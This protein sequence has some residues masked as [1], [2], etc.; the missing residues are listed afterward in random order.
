MIPFRKRWVLLFSIPIYLLCIHKL[1]AT[2]PKKPLAV[3]IIDVRVV[4]EPLTGNFVTLEVDYKV[5]TDGEVQLRFDFPKAVIPDDGTKRKE[6]KFK[7]KKNG[8]YTERIKVKVTDEG[9][10]LVNII[11]QMENAPDSIMKQTSSY[12]TIEHGK[13]DYAVF[14]SI[15]NDFV[16]KSKS[17]KNLKKIKAEKGTDE[18]DLSGLKV[19][20]IVPTLKSATETS[21]STYYVNI[22]GTVTYDDFVDSRMEGL[23][24]GKIHFWFRKSS[25]PNQL[26]HPRVGDYEHVHY[27]NINTNG[28]FSFSFSTTADLTGYDQLVLLVGSGN[29]YVSYN[30]PDGYV[31]STDQGNLTTFG[32]QEGAVLPFNPSN[33]SISLS[34][35]DIEVNSQD[36]SLLRNMMFAGELVK[37]RYGGS[38]PFSMPIIQVFKEAMSDADGRF[39]YSRSWVPFH[40]IES[41]HIT[42][43]P[44]AINAA[45]TT[46]E[47]GHYVNY[48]M[49]GGEYKPMSETSSQVKEGW[50]IFYSFAARNYANRVYTD[51]IIRWDDNTEEDPF[52]T[53]R[54]RGIRYADAGYT[55]YAAFACYLW[56]LYDGY[57]DGNFKSATY[58]GD[59]EDVSGQGKRVFEIMRS[60]SEKNP[61]DFNNMFRNGLNTDLQNSAQNIY[62]NSW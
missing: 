35:I 44:Q 3:E 10:S 5:N 39:S 7:C 1:Y 8:V 37:Q 25:I 2:S 55:D 47:Y 51:G 6:A 32:Y 52:M 31:I 60:M 57:S 28:S 33:T 23:Y 34:S 4:G 26:Y 19:G 43:D 14:S 20:E 22:S 30:L 36:G 49:F 61:G 46:H 9:A 24:G 29:P 48:Q 59:N 38:M 56:N 11:A 17:F 16:K 41:R 45:V 40:W 62:D 58:V 54:F 50:A 53:P 21:T 27:D 42:I 15:K 12:I 13:K 18:G